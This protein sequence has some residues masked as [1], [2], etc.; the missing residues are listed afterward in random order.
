MK[1]SVMTGG[2]EERFGIDGAYARIKEAG[3]DAVDANIDHIW[4]AKDVR[5][6]II[7]PHLQPGTTE[8]DLI[9][10][11]KPWG[12]ASKKY[13]L[14]HAQAHAPYPSMMT[15][16]PDPEYDAFLMEM[17]RR[18]IIAAGSV[19][20]PKLVI[21][22][23]FRAYDYLD[24]RERE[25]ERNMEQYLKL[26]P[27]ARE[28]GVMLLLENMF[29]TYNET[30]YESCCCTGW[31]VKRL[32]DDLNEA[33]GA[34]C[35]G[36]CFDVGHSVLARRQIEKFMT[37]AG[38]SIRAFHIHDNDGIKDKHQAPFTGIAD[39]NG[40]IRGL[41]NIQYKETLNFETFRA[42]EAVPDELVQETL[43]YIAACGRYFAKKAEE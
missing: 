42:I 3:F 4:R 28:A 26:A 21:H 36:F 13:G 27:T 31:E 33:A 19:E 20:I 38:D 6:K 24:S 2:L 34:R 12:E 22:P 1:I 15:K 37:E 5:A 14:P 30:H 43:N 35:F 39:W 10:F 32:V 18:T 41:R 29:S 40:F 16:E 9:E 7:P 17:L 25:R 11:V 23:F 8:K